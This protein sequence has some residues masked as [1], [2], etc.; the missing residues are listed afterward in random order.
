MV[1]RVDHCQQFPRAAAVAQCGKGH[2]RPDR[3]VRVLPAVL[4]Y[5]GNVSLDI[6]RIQVRFVERRVQ[7]LD[8]A[9]VPSNKKLVHRFHRRAGA[10]RHPRRRRERTSFARWNRSGIRDY[11]PNPAESR[12]QSK[13]A[14]T[15]RRPSHAPRY[16][17]ASERPPPGSVRRMTDRRAGVRFP[18]TAQALHTGKIPARRF[19]PC[20]A[21]HQVHAVVPVA[22]ADERQAVLAAAEALQDGPHAV[23]VQ[24]CRFLGA[25]GR[26]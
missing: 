19:H 1:H 17:R 10:C 7:E 26:S 25:R 18:R 24:T 9:V 11:L 23:I 20:R 16:R 5:T 22:R 6:A 14:G 3:R 12:R 21:A 4:P 15:T 8:Q 2:R 13:R